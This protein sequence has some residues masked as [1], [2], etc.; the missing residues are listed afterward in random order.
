MRR[1][2]VLVKPPDD[3]PA[4]MRVFGGFRKRE[5]AVALR[6]K[7]RA[8]VD[9]ELADDLGYAWVMELESPSGVV[10]EARSWAIGGEPR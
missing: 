10:K 1:F 2:V 4:A 6:D 5:K 7:V 9:V 3:H 8:V